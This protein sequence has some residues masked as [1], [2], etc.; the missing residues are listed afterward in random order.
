MLNNPNLPERVEITDVESTHKAD[1]QIAPFI[2]AIAGKNSPERTLPENASETAAELY[3][4][5]LEGSKRTV[6][7]PVD[8][9]AEISYEGRTYFIPKGKSLLLLPYGPDSFDSLDEAS[10]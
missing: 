5:L 6:L 4:Q 9:G 3:L 7:T 10:E 8:G 2:I 1:S